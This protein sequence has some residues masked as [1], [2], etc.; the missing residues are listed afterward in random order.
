M[1]YY[2]HMMYKNRIT[3]DPKIM[4]GKPVITGTRIP[5]ELVLKLLAQGVTAE[6]LVSP[7]YYPHLKKEDIYAA[8]EYARE[9]IVSETSVTQ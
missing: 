4:V 5:V 1:V 9:S 2:D 6:Q 3:I 8:I 7:D